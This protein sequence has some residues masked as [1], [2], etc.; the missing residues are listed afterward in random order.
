[1]NNASYKLRKKFISVLIVN[2][3]VVMLM[4]GCGGHKRNKGA[5]D[6]GK[7]VFSNL[8]KDSDKDNKSSDTDIDN[9]DSNDNNTDNGDKDTGKKGTNKKGTDNMDSKTDTEPVNIEQELLKQRGIDFDKSDYPTFTGGEGIVDTNS[10]FGS[11]A[12]YKYTNSNYNMISGGKIY[13]VN[14]EAKLSNGQ[15][16]RLVGTLPEDGEIISCKLEYDD[17][18]LE[19]EYRNHHNYKLTSTSAA[20]PFTTKQID[21][22]QYPMFAKV[23][24]YQ[25]DGKTLEDCTEAYMNLDK[26][27]HD[28]APYIVFM[29]G[30]IGMVEPKKN[31]YDENSA[32]RIYFDGEWREFIGYDID[33]SAMGNETPIRLFN[34]N[35][36]MTNRAF[37]EIIYAR[38][39]VLRPDRDTYKNQD[40][41]YAQ[42]LPCYGSMHHMKLRKIELLSNYYEDVRNICSASV[43][44]KD[45]KILPIEEIMGDRYS[46]DSFFYDW[47]LDEVGN[48]ENQGN[49][50]SNYGNGGVN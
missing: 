47:S 35:I 7:N 33:T 30:K 50:V 39:P 48:Y 19:V 15:N 46:Y 17:H 28:T 49:N 38:K 22:A 36:V 44:T 34:S 24:R 40:G 37:Y 23:Y 5:G 6:K 9:T 4:S 13:E 16:C 27:Y 29:N 18:G 45:Y 41:S 11:S 21:T 31:F 20:G 2:I 3:A 43:I 12:F 14:L 32:G 1:M 25:S 10:V 26:F 42:Y 8:T